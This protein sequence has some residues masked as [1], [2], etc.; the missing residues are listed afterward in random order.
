MINLTSNLRNFRL[1]AK[2]NIG[3]SFFFNY[4]RLLIDANVV[5]LH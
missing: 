2:L 3:F 1:S 5:N 4:E